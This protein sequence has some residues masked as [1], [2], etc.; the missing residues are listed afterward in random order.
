MLRLSCRAAEWRVGALLHYCD[1]S[2]LQLEDFQMSAD[3]AKAFNLLDRAAVQ[4]RGLTMTSRV[5]VS[6]Q[7]SG[8]R[9]LQEVSTLPKQTAEMMLATQRSAGPFQLT[10]R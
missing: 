2:L 5:L 1:R 7:R 10:L 8:V 6:K 9:V 3:A 4:G